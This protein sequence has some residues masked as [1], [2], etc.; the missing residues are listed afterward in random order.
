M[1]PRH[2]SLDLMQFWAAEP[3]K[4]MHRPFFTNVDTCRQPFLSHKAWCWPIIRSRWIF[5]QLQL[6]CHLEEVRELIKLV[7]SGRVGAIYEQRGINF[8]FE[9]GLFPANHENVSEK[10]RHHCILESLA[11]CSSCQRGML[12]KENGHRKWQSF[13][14]LRDFRQLCKLY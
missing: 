7:A 10:A 14:A 12:L 9:S 8:L 4:L 3:L 5:K 11:N 13:L 1:A 2:H 6:W